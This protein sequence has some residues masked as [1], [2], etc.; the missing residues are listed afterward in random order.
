MVKSR[1]PK[2]KSPKR[3]SPKRGRSKSPRSMSRSPRARANCYAACKTRYPHKRSEYQQF[4][5]DNIHQ[6]GSG[7]QAMKK[8]AA[9]W[10]SYDM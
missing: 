6:F 8:V 5:A 2:R 4:V 7:K 3:K 9:L 10:R 1:S